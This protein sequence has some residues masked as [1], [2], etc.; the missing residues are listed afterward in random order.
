VIDSIFGYTHHDT[1]PPGQT[2]RFNIFTHSKL[3]QEFT[4]SCNTESVE[5]AVEQ[6]QVVPE[7]P[8]IA[9]IAAA[10]LAAVVAVNRFRHK[11]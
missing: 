11:L 5:L 9:A 1:I 8:A 4:T 2:A 3:S 6:V 7:F 10:S